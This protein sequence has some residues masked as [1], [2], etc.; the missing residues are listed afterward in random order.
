[1]TEK[2]RTIQEYV[3]GKQATLA[4]MIAHP[5]PELC[6]QI[7]VSDQGAIGLMTITPGEGAIIAA[8]AADKAGDVKL[9]FVDRFTGCLVFT[10]DVAAV[11]SALSGAVEALTR[12][13]GFSP[14]PLTK[15]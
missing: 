5:S 11:E 3:P 9:E 4:H 12:V 8:D 1:M 10:G 7:G 15:T 6:Q 2:L 13:L 14:A